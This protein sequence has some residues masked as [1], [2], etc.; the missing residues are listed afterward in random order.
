[1]LASMFFEEITENQLPTGRLLVNRLCGF[2]NFGQ[3]NGDIRGL[4]E[5]GG[6][7]V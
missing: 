5:G 1:M 2:M 6:P 4:A 7:A 3:I